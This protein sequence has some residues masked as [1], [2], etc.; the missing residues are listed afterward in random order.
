MTCMQ[1]TPEEAELRSY[2]RTV[3]EIIYSSNN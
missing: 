3:N 1:W 2:D